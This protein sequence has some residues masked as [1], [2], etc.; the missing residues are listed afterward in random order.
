MKIH[1]LSV[2]Y[3]SVQCEQCGE[4]SRLVRWRHRW[5]PFLHQRRWESFWRGAGFSSHICACQSPLWLWRTGAGWAELQSGYIAGTAKLFAILSQYVSGI[6]I[7]IPSSFFLQGMSSPKLAK[8]TI[9]V[10]AKAG[11]RK[12]KQASILLTMWKTSSNYH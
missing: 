7:L 1:S 8:K 2:S 11:S 12:D 4:D 5:E 6:Q 10:G 3:L 9:R